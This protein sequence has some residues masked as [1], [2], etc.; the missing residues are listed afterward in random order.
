MPKVSAAHREARRGQILDAALRCFFEKGF[1]RTSMADIIDASGLSAGAIY[2]HFESKQDLVMEA[3][4][5]VIGRRVADVRTRLAEPPLPDPGEFVQ[6]LMRGI[7]SEGAD[8]RLLVQL[9][10]ES[11]FD[12]G[13]TGLITTVFARLR[14]IVTEYLGAW[15]LERRPADADA[16]RAWAERAAPAMLSLLQGHILQSALLPDFDTDRY[17]DA[18]RALLA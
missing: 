2:L 16:A 6:H 12:E 1:Q 5:R 11:F 7:A 18:V 17:A 8:A 4:R 13:M 15:A 9:W 3:A 10:T 14:E